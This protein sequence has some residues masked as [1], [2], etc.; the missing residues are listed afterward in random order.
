MNVA[1]YDGLL[2]CPMCDE[3]TGLHQCVTAAI[4]RDCED[5]AATATVSS[6]RGVTTVRVLPGDAPGRRDSTVLGF[7]CEGCGVVDSALLIMQHIGLTRVEWVPVDEL[8]R[9][10]GTDWQVTR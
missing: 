9:L 6:A 5:G 1:M 7:W 10:A 4:V 8:V 3:V 2:A